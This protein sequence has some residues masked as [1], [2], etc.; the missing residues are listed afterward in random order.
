MAP[1]LSMSGGCRSKYPSASIM[2]ALLALCN[3]AA[4]LDGI[5]I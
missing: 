3:E 4:L 5:S 2:S 1:P